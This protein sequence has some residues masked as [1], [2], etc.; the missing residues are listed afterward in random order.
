ME[1]RVKE[2]YYTG[3]FDAMNETI[4]F[5]GGGNMASAIIGGLL[6]S[7]LARLPGGDG[8]KKRVWV[9][10]VFDLS[11]DFWKKIRLY[12]KEKNV[13]LLRSLGIV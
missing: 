8:D 3:G 12:C 5:I 11:N 1:E 4:G 2:K 9:D 13:R 10:A 7:G 6:N